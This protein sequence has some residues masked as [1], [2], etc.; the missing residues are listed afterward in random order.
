MLLALCVSDCTHSGALVGKQACFLLAFHSEALTWIKMR[1]S[2]L[3]FCGTNNRCSACV[4]TLLCSGWDNCL[5]ARRFW[6]WFKAVN[7]FSKPICVSA[8]RSTAPQSKNMQI[9]LTAHSVGAG[10]TSASHPA[11]AGIIRNQ[12][13]DGWGVDFLSQVQ[14]EFDILEF[15]KM[16]WTLSCKK[17][18]C[19]KHLLISEDDAFKIWCIFNF[20]SEDNYPLVIVV[21]EVR[22]TLTGVPAYARKAKQPVEPLSVCFSD[23]V[24]AP[25]ADGGQRRRQRRMERGE[26]AS[27][28]QGQQSDCVG[29]D[30]PVG[31]RLLQQGPQPSRPG[32]G[33]QRGLPGAH[34]GCAEAG[35]TRSEPKPEWSSHHGPVIMLPRRW[36]LIFLVKH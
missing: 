34:P 35:G 28:F 33:H 20:L 22:R 16:C 7:V 3:T 10:W 26:A 5:L 36:N 25:K 32:H 30:Q 23:W 12:R 6:V 21:E 17:N 2:L 19:I 4:I 31:D 13:M 14:E 11:T 27:D 18:I 29:A 24:L 9:R 1:R 8:E 15:N